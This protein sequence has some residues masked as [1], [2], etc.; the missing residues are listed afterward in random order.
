MNLEWKLVIYIKQRMTYKG[1]LIKG[2]HRWTKICKKQ[3]TFNEKLHKLL[4]ETK[5]VKPFNFDSVFI[6][7]N[8]FKKKN[9]LRK[10][11]LKALLMEEKDVDLWWDVI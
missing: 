6:E 4:E 3:I 11:K 7:N 9:I 8:E 1:K 10:I 5:K 2:M